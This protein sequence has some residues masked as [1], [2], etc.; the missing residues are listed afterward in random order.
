MSATP[1]ARYLFHWLAAEG[2]RSFHA[3]GHLD[4]AWK[5]FLIGPGREVVGTSTCMDPMRWAPDEELAREPCLVIDAASL[6]CPLHGIRSWEAYHTTREIAALRLEGGDVEAYLKRKRR[7]S[8]ATMIEP[9][10][11]FVEGVVGWESVVAVGYEVQG[12]GARAAMTAAVEVAEARALPTLRMSWS[13]G[14]AADAEIE[15]VVDAL[16]AP[17]P[18]LCP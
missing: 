1:P 13:L 5:H 4:P 9:D 7:I 11:I 17:A 3:T 12:L 6:G 16:R 10:E 8:E 15:A 14:L 2:L 18:G